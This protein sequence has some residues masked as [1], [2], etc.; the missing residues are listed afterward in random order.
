M[1]SLLAQLARMRRI[2]LSQTPVVDTIPTGVQ[3]PGTFPKGGILLRVSLLAI[4]VAA[5]AAI[6]PLDASDER[7]IETE[8]LIITWKKDAASEAD[9][10]SFDSTETE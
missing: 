7:R 5:G 10:Q 6:V 1:A 8:H 4:L 3:V 9:D 2:G